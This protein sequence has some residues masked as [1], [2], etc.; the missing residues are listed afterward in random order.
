M[1]VNGRRGESAYAYLTVHR[2]RSVPYFSSHP[3]DVVGPT[4]HTTGAS[5]RQQQGQGYNPLYIG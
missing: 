2:Y 3:L 4:L 1:V 5:F